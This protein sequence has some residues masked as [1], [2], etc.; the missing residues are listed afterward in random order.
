M[1]NARAWRAARHCMSLAHIL[2]PASRP[3]PLE[4]ERV[5]VEPHLDRLL[6]LLV[7]VVRAAA[8]DED[9][10]HDGHD[11]SPVNADGTLNEHALHLVRA[12]LDSVHASD[13]G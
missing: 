8:A 5:R 6:L 9:D 1:F 10:E 2:R 11:H 3:H 13:A 7:L 4:L 12:T